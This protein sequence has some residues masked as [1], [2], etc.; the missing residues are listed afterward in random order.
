MKS[1]WNYIKHRWIV[2]L[3]IFCVASTSLISAVYAKYVAVKTAEPAVTVIAQGVIDI[4]VSDL[5]GGG[6]GGGGGVGG[7]G[8]SYTVS[9]SSSTNIVTYIRAT[10]VV[11]WQDGEGNIW[12]IPP[13]EN[14]DYTISAPNCTLLS[15][16]YYYYNGTRKPGE[17]FGIN[18]TQNTVKDGFSLHVQIFA[19][20]IQCV[21]SDLTT[22]TWGATYDS[23]NNKWTKI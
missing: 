16:G 1:V 4:D 17:G 6:G 23:V 7:G 21:P 12:A 13:V 18:V 20:S 5:G 14:T 15:D 9:N 11:N 19:E 2:L 22:T 3:L 8:G 10:V